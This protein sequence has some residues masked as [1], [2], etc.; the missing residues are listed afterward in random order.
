MQVRKAT[1]HQLGERLWQLIADVERQHGVP[2]FGEIQL[3]AMAEGEPESLGV[4]AERN[5]G[6]EAYGF[7]VPTPDRGIWTLEL[8]AGPGIYDWFLERVLEV[9]E[10]AGV[11]EVVLWVHSPAVE[12]PLRLVRPERALYRMSAA[13]TATDPPVPPDGV[14]IRGVDVPRDAPALIRL[15][16]QAFGDHP[17]QGGW[18]PRDLETRLALSWF[19]P[20]G[21]RTAWM[22]SRLV[23]FN[24][25]K[26]HPEPGPS[27]ET[28]GEIYSIAVDPS[29][30]GR[31]LGRT[32]AVEGLRYLAAN[33]GAGRAILYVDSSNT[34][35][36]ELYRSLGFATEHV[37]RAYR[38]KAD[39]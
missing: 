28:V 23:A 4:V 29:F 3:A 34:A 2:P 18:T 14:T 10:A 21:L 30:Q 16:N 15:N 1:P 36:L 39:R 27:G 19:D 31:G 12:P 9:L 38:W 17:E 5:G 37:D 20:A 32:I 6:T 7:A 25:T 22:G 13:I 26:V 35:A 24:W 33:R 8:A 11:A